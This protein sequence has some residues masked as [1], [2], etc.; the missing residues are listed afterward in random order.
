MHNYHGLPGCVYAPFML[1]FEGKWL[2]FRYNAFVDILD[3]QHLGFEE[4]YYTLSSHYSLVN[5]CLHTCCIS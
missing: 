5:V 4:F 1:K 3:W 2:I